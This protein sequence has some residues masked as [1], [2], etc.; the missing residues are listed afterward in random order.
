METDLIFGKEVYEII[1][2]AIEVHKTLGHGFLE[3][4]YQEA[5]EYELS[6]RKIPFSSQIELKVKYKDRYLQK[7]YIADI[8][9]YDKIIIELKALTNLSGKEEAQVINYLKATGFKVGLLINFGSPNKL[10]WKRFVH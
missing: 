3:A 5:L 4:I 9:A 1:G 6:D 10:E 2:A 8:I 7:T